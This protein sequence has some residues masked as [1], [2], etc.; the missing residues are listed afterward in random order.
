MILDVAPKMMKKRNLSRLIIYKF[1]KFFV[2]CN[3]VLV[4][5]IC[6]DNKLFKIRGHCTVPILKKL[7]FLLS[8]N[9]KL[10]YIPGHSILNI[11]IIHLVICYQINLFME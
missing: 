1:S 3:I 8:I 7:H 2:S 11:F 6:E 4:R 5:Q 10:P 9:G